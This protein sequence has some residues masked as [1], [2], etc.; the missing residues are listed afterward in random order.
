[1]CAR[2]G[3]GQETCPWDTVVVGAM[4]PTGWPPAATLRSAMEG[5]GLKASVQACR[6]STGPAWRLL[7]SVGWLHGWGGRTWEIS[8]PFSQ[9]CSQK[10]KP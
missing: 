6:R 4:F 9:F 7:W 10:I 5:G 1:M 2:A 3:G 8:T